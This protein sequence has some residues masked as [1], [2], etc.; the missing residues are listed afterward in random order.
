M[1]ANISIVTAGNVDAGKSTSVGVQMMLTNIINGTIKGNS[2]MNYLDDGNG[3]M[4]S[5]VSNFKHEIETGK[6]SSIST[7]CLKCGDNNVVLIDLCGHEKYLKT[8]LY[9]ITGFFPD[10]GILFIAANKGLEGMAR[11]HLHIFLA[12]SLTFMIV[13]TRVDK[14]VDQI[15]YD[16]MINYLKNMFRNYNRKVLQINKY[17]I[18]AEPYDIN[19]LGPDV[20]SVM[21]VTESLKDTHY[22]IPILS[23]SNTTGYYVDYLN[24]ILVNAKP[25]NEDWSADVDYSIFYIDAN[26]Q[27]PGRGIVVSGILKGKSIKVGDIL[28]IGPIGKHFFPMKVGSIHDNVKN[29]VPELFNR[30]RGCLLVKMIGPFKKS[31][32]RKHIKKGTIIVNKSTLNNERNLVYEFRCSMHIL[33][34]KKSSVNMKDGYCPIIHCNGIRQSARL[35]IDDQITAFSKGVQIASNTIVSLQPGIEYRN[36]RLQFLHHPVF[37]EEGAKILFKE[38]ITKGVGKVISIVPVSAT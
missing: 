11:E 36:I 10:Y 2:D 28:S 27:I 15:E 31:F 4:R 30:Q 3:K 12:Y 33:A 17:A 23:I 14:V 38:N 1:A 8:T 5:L 24:Q 22:T 35:Y 26:Y 29:D 19:N 25:K 9:G 7:R 16:K 18:D 6:T 37:M 32:T 21:E 20:P 34:A 13:I